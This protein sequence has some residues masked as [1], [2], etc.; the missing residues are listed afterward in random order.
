MPNHEHDIPTDP[1][2]LRQFASQIL[3][4]LTE[5]EG[6]YPDSEDKYSNLESRH[7]AEI[8]NRDMIITKLRRQLFGLHKDK[9]GSSGEGRDQLGLK[10]EDEEAGHEQAVATTEND[11]ADES[12][13]Q[14]KPIRRVLPLRAKQGL[15][16]SPVLSSINMLIISRF[17]ARARLWPA[18]GLI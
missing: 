10:L 15:G 6:K 12:V 2:E 13:P 16:C 14:T 5:L 11:V 9:F 17:I 4:G 18:K 3:T 7:M 1:T 8:Q